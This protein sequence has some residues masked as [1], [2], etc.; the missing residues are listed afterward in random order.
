M[1]VNLRIAQKT[2]WLPRGGGPQG[3]SPVLVPRGVGIGFLPYYMHRRKDIYG[4][5]AMDFRP[6]R[7]EE[8]HLANIGYAYVPFH[9]G[10]RICL[11]SKHPISPCICFAADTNATQRILLY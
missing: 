2:T 1:P 10:P 9:G 6:E 8:P 7:W 4:E 5:D 11:G 3:T